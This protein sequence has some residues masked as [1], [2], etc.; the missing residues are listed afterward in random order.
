[1]KNL[2]LGIVTIFIAISPAYAFNLSFLDYSS[3][4]YF[5]K[6]DWAIAESTAQKALNNARDNMK[7]NWRNPETNAH[8]YFLPLNT[9]TQNGR[10]CR[11]MKIFSVAHEVTG[12]SVY[13]FCKINGEWKI[14]G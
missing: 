9:T 5:T 4:Y 7:V 11:R 3:V 12:Q 10:T 6:S 2:L 8:G 1:M 13:L 14:S